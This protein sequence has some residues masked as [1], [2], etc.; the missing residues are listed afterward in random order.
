MQMVWIIRIIGID[1]KKR[2]AWTRQALVGWLENLAGQHGS[3]AGHITTTVA[4]AFHLVHH[5]AP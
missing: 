4:F 5:E 3:M 2:T 1:Y